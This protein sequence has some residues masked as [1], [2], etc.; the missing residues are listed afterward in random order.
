MSQDVLTLAQDL[1]S[2]PSVTP[3]DEGCQTLMAERL[4][5]RGFDIEPMVFEDTTNMWARRGKEGP[6]FCFAGHTDVVP[7]GD[8]NRWHTPPFDPVVIDGYLHGRGA[9]DM[10]GSLAAMVVATER[11]VEKHPDHNGSI[12]FLITSDEE[13]PFI[14]GT[15]RVIDTL[16]A[17]N[18]KI[19]WSLVGEPSST[20]KLGDIV[21]NGRRGSLTGNLTINGIQGHVAYP[22]LADNPIHKAAPV[23]DELARM[24]WDNGNAFF[25]P[26][27]FQIANINGG[28]GASNVIPGALEVMFNFRYSTE[29]TA[30]ILIQRVL[31]ILDAHGLDYEINWIYNGLPFLTGDGP[32][33]DATRAAI[34]Q[35]TGADT[36]PQTTGG[37]SDGRFIAPTGAHVIE[38]GPVNATI[39]KVNEC[40]KV[41]DL[42]LLAQC[43]EVILEK[44]LC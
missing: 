3:L 39:H 36:D 21:K 37:T 9:A 42:E 24:K 19:T 43:Y 35:V 1:I 20:H 26:T 32:L 41:A 30:E 40:V 2:R 10:K 13:G 22:H 44:L 11:F 25:P 8:L 17:R 29:V 18:E 4:A 14:N 23:L 27:S 34:K 28:T 31:N 7:V 5:A 16:E 15:T 33:L 38:L 12:A 6:L